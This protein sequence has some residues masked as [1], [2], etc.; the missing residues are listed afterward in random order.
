MLSACDSNY[1]FLETPPKVIGDKFGFTEGPVWLIKQKMWIFTDIPNNKVY[2]LNSEGVLKTFD[3]DSGYANG[4]NIDRQG[5]IW[6]ARHDGKV[7]Y[8][9]E[10]GEE[11]VVASLYKGKRLN[12]AQMI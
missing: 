12:I 7:S 10:S 6:Y 1:R 11:V 5:N 8:K 4:L 3:N 9:A 2:S